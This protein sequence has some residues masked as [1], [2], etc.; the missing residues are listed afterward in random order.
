MFGVYFFAASCCGYFALQIIMAWYLQRSGRLE[1]EITLEHYQDM[2]KLLF[3]FG[4]VFWAYIA[5]SQFMLI[6]YAN[7]PEETT[8]Y[9]ARTLGPWRTVSWILLVFHFAVP[10]VLLVTKHTKRVPAVLAGI[11]GL[12]LVLHFVDMYWSVMPRVPE[13]LSARTESLATLTALY[14]QGELNIGWAPSP[15]DLTLVLGLVGPTRS[16]TRG[17]ASRWPS[18]TCESGPPT[19]PKGL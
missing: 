13:Q 16:A 17:W 12:M 5:Y 15:M 9:M 8:W 19:G 6:W 14:E 4:I 7:I 1:N 3:A 11:A 10:F 18:R 2:G